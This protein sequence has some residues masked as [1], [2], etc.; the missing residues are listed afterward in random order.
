MPH[1]PK[2]PERQESPLDVF[3]VPFD[4]LDTTPPAS[5]P[6]EMRSAAAAGTASH[7]HWMLRGDE[8]LTSLRAHVRAA[9]DAIVMAGGRVS[10]A[11][12]A[13]TLQRLGLSAAVRTAAGNKLQS[14]RH[15]FVV[16][17]AADASDA[18]VATY[19]VDP[20]F[21]EQFEIAHP[22][23]R[24][25]AIVKSLPQEVVATPAVLS[26]VVGLLAREMA[27]SFADQGH[28]LPPWRSCNALLCRWQL[29]A[30]SFGVAK[31]LQFDQA[32]AGAK[33]GAP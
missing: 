14:L 24:Y 32:A 23:P 25:D 31:R 1:F 8:D 22:T 13:A 19:V 2:L 17:A 27:R 5:I 26:Q 11:S 18:G 21:R 15:E 29:L 28:D 10:P 16:V 3:G 7:L 20:C 33:A 30:P 4:D 12:V 6:F 9:T